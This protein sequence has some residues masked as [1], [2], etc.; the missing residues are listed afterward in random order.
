MTGADYLSRW[1]HWFEPR[2]GCCVKSGARPRNPAPKVRLLPG[3]SWYAMIWRKRLDD[4]SGPRE[5][6][7]IPGGSI[8]NTRARLQMRGRAAAGALVIVVLLVAGI[9]IAHSL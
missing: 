8:E 6:P 2:R 7:L 9:V 1:G 4:S 3:V 5:T